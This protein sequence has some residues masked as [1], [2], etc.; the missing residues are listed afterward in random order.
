MS[1]KL[2][3]PEEAAD[4]P[5]RSDLLSVSTA[6]PELFQALTNGLA[7][8]SGCHSK[9][10][11]FFCYLKIEGPPSGA[12]QPMPELEGELNRE[13]LAANAGCC[14]GGG[15]G[16]RYSYIDLALTDV[17]HAAPILRKSLAAHSAPQRSWL[18]FHDDDLVGEW[19]GIYGNTPPPPVEDAEQEE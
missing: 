5:G 18:L 7:F 17:K 2:E 4:Y 10:R 6:C 19:I 1:L 12:P 15:A 3:P 11:E 16:V 9:L 13:L 8:S 14:L